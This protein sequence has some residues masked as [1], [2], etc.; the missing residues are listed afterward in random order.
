MSAVSHVTIGGR[1]YRVEFNW[2]AISAFLVE[3]GR[4]TMEGL[5]SLTTLRPSDIVPLA[6]AAIS[7]GERLEGR[8]LEITRENLGENLNAGVIR[9][10]I[11][12]FA[13]QNSNGGGDESEPV[14]K[15]KKKSLFQRSG[16]SA[17]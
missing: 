16:R 10:I 3:S 12:I 11:G 13:E 8:S 2:N 15:S 7:E 9:E 5:A 4:D 14:E 17:E 1:Q 6:Y